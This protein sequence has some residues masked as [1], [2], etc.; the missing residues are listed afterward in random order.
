MADTD[1]ERIAAGYDL[2]Y[3]GIARSPTFQRL[4]REHSLGHDYPAGFEHISFLTL[5]EMSWMTDA[6]QLAAGSVLV[7]L[8]C[9][10]GGPGLWVAKT[11]GSR[12][13]GVDISLVALR[14]ARERAERLQ[15]SSSSRFASGTFAES[16]LETG[17]AHG[18]MTV[19]ALQYAPDK[20]A[21]LDEAARVLRPGG[22]LAF[23]CFTFEPA[24]VA[25]I[26][27]F[28]ADPVDDYR[29]LL[30]KAG[31]GVLSYDDSEDWNARVSDTY[32]SVVDA[33][34]S[35][36]TELG[37]G[38]YAALSGEMA[39]TLSLKPYRGRVLVAAQKH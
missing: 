23:A 9:G 27:I 12:L 4:W 22:R 10:M 32:Q 36:T 38:A 11:T 14:H 19:D 15:M 26:P 13:V 1:V 39:L 29:P 17:S 30:A 34:T 16:G 37:E 31:L 7:D 6:L 21:A 18:V 5:T 33:K 35:L 28:G 8:A 25:G 2:V 24:H 3:D 20:Q